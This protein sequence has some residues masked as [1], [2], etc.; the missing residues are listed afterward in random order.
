MVELTIN[1]EPRAIRQPGERPLLWVLRHDLGLRGTK[2]GCGVGKCGACTVH[3]DGRP[4]HACTT[5]LAECAGRE[6]TTIE[7]LAAH[8]PHPVIR[9][10]VDEQVPQCG[11]CQ[12]AQVLATDALLATDPSPGDG[13]MDAALAPVLCRCG[14]YQRI[15]RAVHRAARYRREG[16]PGAGLAPTNPGPAPDAGTSLNPWVRIHADHT[17]T[18]VMGPVEMGQGAHTG[19]AVA[20]AEEL[21]VDPARI[22]TESAPVDPAYTNPL[23][24][25]QTTGGSTSVRGSFAKYRRAGASARE[26]LVRAAAEDWGVH[27]NECRAADGQVHHDPSGRRAG[28]GDLVERA[29]ALRAPEDPLLKSPDHFQR[30]GRSVPRLDARDLVTGRVTYGQD[31]TRPGMQ[32]ATILR[33]PVHGGR[34][35]SLRLN[36]A[37]QVP[38]FRQALALDRG[39]AILADDFPGALAARARL[40][41]QWD[42]GPNASLDNAAI[43]QALDHAL[44]RE[45]TIQDQWGDPESVL[46]A[47]GLAHDAFY[48]TPFLAHMP[49]EPMNATVEIGPDGCDVWTGTQAPQDARAVA[50]EAAGLGEERVRIHTT[51]MGGTFGRRLETDYVREAVLVARSAGVPVQVLWTRADDTRH[52]FYRPAHGARLE[53]ALG[54]DGHMAAWWLRIAG[55]RMAMGGV[56]MPYAV[57]H[58]R[59]ER[60]VADPGIPCGAWRSVEASNNAFP[61]ECFVDELAAAAGRDPLEFRLAHL[62][63]APHHRAVLETA[64]KRAGWGQPA[65]G[66]RQG[67]AVYE[68]FGSVVA[69]VAEVRLDGDGGL[70][71]PRVFCAID[72]G[73]AVNPDGI[74]SQ[75]E[76]AVAWALSA[77]L[78]GDITIEGGATVEATYA[79]EPI[80]TFPEMPRVEVAILESGGE[81]GGVGEPGV[82]PLAPAVANAVARAMGRRPRGLPLLDGEHRL[83]L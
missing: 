6:V 28:Y 50:A 79:D 36:G 69:E 11:F 12:P 18:L 25:H 49:M 74:R 46:A 16:L 39:V 80:V 37:D 67:I 14:T 5:E 8:H 48:R 22:R 70:E 21:E 19:L 26:V 29:A 23:F 35:A 41:P 3:L 62:A 64:A 61:I 76:G 4:V 71:V 83:R 56:R 27:A 75:M 65:E 51:A 81:L 10:W 33:C 58:Y 47:T 32:T 31:I 13:A 20:A 40:E 17:V 54:A 15:R 43:R 24:G 59:E 1:G 73:R 82:P 9:A 30:V 45:G 72:C 44:E 52:D 60:V 78:Y 7:G 2:Y 53:A 57:P 38:G 77:A 34:L 66:C 68:C 42:P 63:D 55:D